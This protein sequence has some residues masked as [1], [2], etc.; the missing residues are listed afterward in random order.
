L[1]KKSHDSRWPELPTRQPQ[2]QKASIKP[3]K[4]YIPELT[5]RLLRG[6]PTARQLAPGQHPALFWRGIQL[7]K[8]ISLR[9]PANAL[10]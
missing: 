10:L 9:L 2:R 5:K 8:D 7:G 1:K 3:N 4:L 6:Y